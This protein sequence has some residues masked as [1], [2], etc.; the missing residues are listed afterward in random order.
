[1]YGPRNVYGMATILFLL[2]KFPILPFPVS[3]DSTFVGVHVR[4]VCGAALF[5][6][7]T[8]KSIGE[9]YNVIDNSQYTIREFVEFVCPLMGV[10]II[11]IFIPKDLLLKAADGAADVMKSVSKVIGTRP[12]IEKDM[13]YY[14]KATYTFS[15]DKIKK[16]GYN[17]EYPDILEGIRETIEWYKDNGY[18]DRWDLW[19]KALF[20]KA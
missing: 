9:A 20:T 1:V 13:V 7:Q 19:Q 18:L 12:F 4:D 10:H 16:L 6:A 2:A 3:M 8:D 5:L 15:N 17:L 11:P 14:L